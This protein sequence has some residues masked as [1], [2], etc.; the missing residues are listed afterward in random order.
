MS[1]KQTFALNE[2]AK[3]WSSKNTLLPNQ[4]FKSSAV[5]IGF[6]CDKCYNE[7]ESKLCHITDGSWCP[8]CK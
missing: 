4:V 3:Y 1:E 5:K 8:K 7:F 6:N 2:R